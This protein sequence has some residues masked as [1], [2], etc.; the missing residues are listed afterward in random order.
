MA[1]L[2][3]IACSWHKPLIAVKTDNWKADKGGLT[4]AVVKCFRISQ[5]PRF[6]GHKK[7]RELC[8]RCFDENAAGS[9][10]PGC[11]SDARKKILLQK[12][13]LKNNVGVVTYYGIGVHTMFLQGTPPP[14]IK[15][16]NHKKTCT[17]A[18]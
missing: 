3:I 10:H 6:N 13:C 11:R 16:G 4:I 17:K 1:L 9:R 15:N 18:I 12:G 14:Y 2:T 8:G 7:A 5:Q